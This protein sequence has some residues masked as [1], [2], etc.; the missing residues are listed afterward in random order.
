MDGVLQFEDR[1]SLDSANDRRTF[2][3]H[4]HRLGN[5]QAHPSPCIRMEEEG[6]AI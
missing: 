2:P 5:E 3:F 6:G 1:E 4:F